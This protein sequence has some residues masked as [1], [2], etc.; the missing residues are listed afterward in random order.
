M[1]CKICNSDSNYTFTAKVLK[2]YDVKYFHCR[3]CGFLQT[4]EPYWLKESYSSVIGTGDTGIMKRNRTFIKRTSVLLRFLFDKNGRYLDYAGGHGIFTRAMRDIG[5]N[6]FWSDKY[7]ENLYA[8]GF[9]YNGSDKINLV[10]AFECFEHFENPVEDINNIIDIS[11]NILFSTRTFTG[12]PPDSQKWWYYSLDDGQH[13]SFYSTQT[14]QFLAS[15]HNLNLCTDNKSF[16][17]LSEK[18]INNSVYNLLL[19][20]SVLGLGNLVKIGMVSRTESD[21]NLNKEKIV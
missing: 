17:L 7:A 11:R 20:L 2:K 14:L 15:K 16:H 12:S 13:I 4:E 18:K 5:F 1:F 19:K 10:T 21:H 6:Y 8:H 9:E 3:S